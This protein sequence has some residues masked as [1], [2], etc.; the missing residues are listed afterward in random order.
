MCVCVRYNIEYVYMVMKRDNGRNW[1][2]DQHSCE[3]T[4]VK[5]WVCW[6][7]LMIIETRSILTGCVHCSRGAWPTG[8]K[9]HHCRKRWITIT[10]SLPYCYIVVHDTMS[11]ENRM[12]QLFTNHTSHI[13]LCMCVVVGATTYNKE[14]N[15]KCVREIIINSFYCY[16]NY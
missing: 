13:A 12:L 5:S 6:F 15:S 7:D 14:I 11:T 10:L 4:K 8:R 3:C 9:R 1:M 16:S 2:I